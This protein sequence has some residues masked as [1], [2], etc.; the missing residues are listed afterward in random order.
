MAELLCHLIGDYCLQ[1]QW[2]A[3]NKTRRS[4]PCLVHCL[5]YTLPF[6]LLTRSPAALAVIFV[7]HFL[8][9]RFRLAGYWVRLYRIGQGDHVPPFLAV[10]L[11]I[12]VDNTM[13]L[14]TNHLALQFL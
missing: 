1:N 4:W 10:W 5:L 12:I 14:L 3:D 7:T 2:M 13:H 11:L 8:I 9:D 6:L